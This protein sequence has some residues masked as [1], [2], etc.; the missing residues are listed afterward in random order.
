MAKEKKDGKFQFVFLNLEADEE[1]IQ[2]AVRQA[3]MIIN[4][5]M[6]NPQ[7]PTKTLIAV[8]VRKE[9]GDGQQNGAAA[10][11]EV[12]EVIDA[13]ADALDTNGTANPA[14]AAGDKPKRERRVPRTPPLL[15]DFDPKDADVSLEDFAKQKDTSTQINKYLVIAAWFHKYKD[16]KEI[17]PSH[18]RTCYQLLGWVPPDDMGGQFRTLK[19]PQYSFFG[20][21]SKNGLWEITIIGLNE[22]EK[23]K[24]KSESSAEE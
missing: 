6:G 2:E 14:A 10:E 3:G 5:G 18:I 4:R 12:Y 20:N 1:T 8:P 23:M 7:T 17:G 21:G 9:L 15:K 19:K 16:V 11:Q 13:E 22:V 24:P